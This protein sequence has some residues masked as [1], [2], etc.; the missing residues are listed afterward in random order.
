MRSATKTKT[1]F[2]LLELLIVISIIAILIAL[3]LPAIQQ[4]RE[5]ARMRQCS[6]NMM[7]I[8]IAL[9]NYHT[10]YKYLPS[11]CVNETGPVKEGRSERQSYGEVGGMGGFGAYESGADDSGDDEEAKETEAPV[12]DY[13][14]RISWIAQILPQLGLGNI[15]R[16]VDFNNPD[17]SFLSAKQLQ[18]YESPQPAN[19]DAQQDKR[20][21]ASYSAGGADYGSGDMGSSSFDSEQPPMPPQIVIS[22]LICSSSPRGPGGGI[23]GRAQSDYA[24]CHASSTTAI[25]SDNDGLLYLNSSESLYDI[26]DGAANT[27]LV[28]EKHSLL[29]DNGFLTGDFSTLRNTGGSI[30]DSNIRQ[31]PYQRMQNGEESMADPAVRGFG[32]YHNTCSNF[33]LADGSVR[34]I[35]NMISLD[36]YKKLGSRN[37]GGL[38]SASDF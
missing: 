15:Y 12:E 36:V 11:G 17:R 13:G 31:D 30:R 8:G 21:T 7:Q 27:F 6:N 4:A 1:G 18:Y 33:L 37:D 20:E 26:F 9:H 35:S 28:G 38:I 16:Q 3:L 23:F 24:G 29:N 19:T 14:N 32:S 10:A 25:D 34:P 22:L 5:Q 2:T